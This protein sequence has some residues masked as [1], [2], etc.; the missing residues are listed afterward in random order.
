MC[1]DRCKGLAGKRDTSTDGESGY[2]TAPLP[3]K[4]TFVHA[5]TTQVITHNTPE[6]VSY[7]HLVCAHTRTTNKQNLM[8]K[9]VSY[10]R[11]QQ[12]MGVLC[13]FILV[14]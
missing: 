5:S 11:K 1:G 14:L 13:E 4:C 8:F 2:H 6:T 3:C 10:F 7:T 12:C 9:E